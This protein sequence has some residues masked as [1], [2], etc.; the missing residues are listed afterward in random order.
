M[1]D[2]TTGSLDRQVKTAAILA[3]LSAVA[4]AIMLAV[5]ETSLDKGITS[6]SM[7]VCTFLACLAVCAMIL[8]AIRD[9][10]RKAYHRCATALNALQSEKNPATIREA[11]HNLCLNVRDPLEKKL[12]ELRKPVIEQQLEIAENTVARTRR[13]DILGERLK[14]MRDHA[15]ARIAH[16]RTSHPKLA[17]RDAAVRKLRHVKARRIQLE[18]DVD[19]ILESASWWQKL[20]YDYPDYRKMDREIE[21]LELSVE[22]FLSA[23]D[24]DICAAE[25]KID[26]AEAYA[27]ERM[28]KYEANA[29]SAIPVSWHMPCD[30]DAIARNALLLGALTVPVSIWNDMA[31]ANEVYDALRSVNGAYA[32]VNDFEIWLQCL[33][34]PSE[35]LTGLMSLTK[36]ALFEAHVTDSTGGI[37]HEH[38]NTPDTDIVIDGTAYQIKATGSAA[39]VESVDPA[40][41]VIATSEVAESTGA[42]DGGMS[43]VELDSA[44]SLALGD[45]VVD[46]VDTVMDAAFT[47]LGGICIL[48]TLRG[49]NH[50]IDRN[51]EGIDKEEAI[52]EGVGVAVTGSIKATVD[53]AEMG[54]KVAASRPSRFAGRQ[55][56]KVLKRIDRSLSGD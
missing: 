37:L 33:T 49:I 9:S 43:I 2:A 11:W 19:E 47:G 32:D 42:I 4:A 27:Q 26:A 29:M 34:M 35:S 16:A 5:A 53:L 44:T 41:P 17:A 38:F 3:A 22:R 21:K 39:Y 40:I 46:G 25:A 24:E 45:T 30:E 8:A 6:I 1:T 12:I 15:T 13:Q 55:V 28:E 31:Q 52:A 20:N 36:G 51:R 56:V 54:C 50:A 48:A 14:T 7:L 18:A 23:N 10:R